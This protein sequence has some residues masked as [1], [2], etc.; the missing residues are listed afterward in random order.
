MSRTRTLSITCNILLLTTTVL[1]GNENEFKTPLHAKLFLRFRGELYVS[2]C[3]YIHF[4]QSVRA[5]ALSAYYLALHDTTNP[6]KHILA[7]EKTLQTIE[8]QLIE[9]EEQ[10]LAELQKEF[11]IDA[12]AWKE[13][14]QTIK[15]LKKFNLNAMRHAWPNTHHDKTIPENVLNTLKA[16]LR[17]ANINPESI[18]IAATNEQK[19]H[20]FAQTYG[21]IW[22][23][24]LHVNHVYQSQKIEFFLS[25][26][27][28]NPNT[29]FAICAHEIEHLLQQHTIMSFIIKLYIQKHTNASDE[30]IE[31]NPVYHR[32]NTIH[33]SQAEIF[34]SLRD[35]EIAHAMATLRLTSFY[36]EHLYEAHF[37]TLS[38]I[39]MLWKVHAQ[40]LHKS[41]YIAAFKNKCAWLKNKILSLNH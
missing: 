31:K 12:T 4:C 41:K 35:P 24:D 40:L 30:T 1:Q 10:I 9:Q 6:E 14:L 27:E 22:H 5:A 13:C 23:Q 11:N 38:I 20:I 28:N 37:Y 26:L 34:P 33:E 32:L 19:D 25:N 16:L 7:I 29:I 39:S 3:L 8:K 17:K 18:S 36:P 15:T 2:I 21:Y